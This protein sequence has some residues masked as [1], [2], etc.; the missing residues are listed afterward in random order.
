MDSCFSDEQRINAV[1]PMVLA[2]CQSLGIAPEDAEDVVG[3]TYRLTKRLPGRDRTKPL[4][5][6]ATRLAVTFPADNWVFSAS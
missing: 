1:K 3:Q 6:S 2:H 5:C 4:I